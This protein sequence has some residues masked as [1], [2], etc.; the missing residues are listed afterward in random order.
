MTIAMGNDDNDIDGDGVMGNEVGDDG[1]G[2]MGNTVGDDGNGA[3]GN[4][5]DNDNGG[6]ATI[7]PHRCL[8]PHRPQLPQRIF[9]VPPSLSLLRRHVHPLPPPYISTQQRDG[10]QCDGI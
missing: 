9:E 2:A 4:D 7:P 8:A 5:N 6:D 1:G 10:R 3:T